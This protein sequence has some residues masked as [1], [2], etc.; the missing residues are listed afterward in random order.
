MLSGCLDIVKCLLATIRVV[1][2]EGKNHMKKAGAQ[3]A[4]NGKRCPLCNHPSHTMRRY[5]TGNLERCSACEIVFLNLNSIPAELDSSDLYDKSYFQTH[6][7]HLK[8]EGDLAEQ[9]CQRRP[10]VEFMERFGSFSGKVLDV[11]CA[12]GLFLACARDHGWEP[13]GFDVSEWA[14][15]FARDKLNL[16][17]IACGPSLTEVNLPQNYFDAVTLWHVLE[18]TPNPIVELLTIRNLL[19]PEG[20]LII[21][22]PNFGSFQARLHKERW[23]GLDLPYHLFHFTS[24]TLER[25]ADEA[26]FCK[27]DA[28]FEMLYRPSRI[29]SAVGIRPHSWLY[30]RFARILSGRDMTFVFRKCS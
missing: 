29:F 4:Q 13:W 18:H 23:R 14:C 5:V 24:Y 20:R 3:N 17:N 30:Q 21:Q 12:S 8:P 9:V 28:E 6:I 25:V 11:G 10:L 2:K 26:G 15:Q 16:A 7:S 1:N 22:V 27:V 19:K